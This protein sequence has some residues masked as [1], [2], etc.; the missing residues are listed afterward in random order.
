MNVFL[1]AREWLNAN[2]YPALK[3]HI[4]CIFEFM[5]GTEVSHCKPARKIQGYALQSS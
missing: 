4:V 3:H 1:V 2:A 5:G